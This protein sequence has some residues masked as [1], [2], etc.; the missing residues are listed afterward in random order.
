MLLGEV[1]QP[2]GAGMKARIGTEIAS[3][4][5]ESLIGRGGMGEVYLATQAVPDRKIALKLLP[6]ELAAEPAFR[7]RFVRVLDFLIDVE[8]DA[9]HEVGN[10]E[11][12]AHAEQ[13]SLLVQDGLGIV[14]P[15]T[16]AV[17]R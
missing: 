7:E 1:L 3:Y 15:T 8:V 12:D 13:P 4:R 10:Q 5:I 16:R 2:P 6:H 14:Y 17:G 11:I 9:P